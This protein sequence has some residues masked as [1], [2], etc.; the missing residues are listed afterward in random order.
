VVESS[1]GDLNLQRSVV[2]PERVSVELVATVACVVD[3]PG[4]SGVNSSSTLRGA[5]DA[6][7]KGSEAR[8]TP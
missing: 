5:T 2:R 7:M 8:Q 3:F 4:G 1:R 6:A